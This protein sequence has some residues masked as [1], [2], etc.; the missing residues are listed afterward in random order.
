MVNWWE[1]GTTD[2]LDDIKDWCGKELHQLIELAQTCGKPNPSRLSTET[3]GGG[4]SLLVTPNDI[5]TRGKTYCTK[6]G[7][8]VLK[9]STEIVSYFKAKMH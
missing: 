2:W 8:L 5:R 6:Y 4:M 7:K 1:E 9:K 3:S